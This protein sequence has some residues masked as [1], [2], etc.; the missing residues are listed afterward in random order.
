MLHV[1]NVRTAKGC[2]WDTHMG[3]R[4]VCMCGVQ[5]SWDKEVFTELRYVRGEL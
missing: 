5:G 1:V 3:T 2:R 4:P